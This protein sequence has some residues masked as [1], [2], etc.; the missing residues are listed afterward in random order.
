M[1]KSY[2]IVLQSEARRHIP[3]VERFSFDT[4][5]PYTERTTNGIALFHV[6]S[7]YFIPFHTSHMSHLLSKKTCIVL[8]PQPSAIT[9]AGRSPVSPPTLCLNCVEEYRKEGS[10]HFSSRDTCHS[11]DWLDALLGFFV[12][13]LYSSCPTLPSLCHSCLPSYI[14]FR[15]QFKCLT[16]CTEFRFGK[17]LLSGGYLAN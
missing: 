5:S 13:L 3:I 10:Q 15:N 14:P 4:R 12:Y 16:G 2:Y 7:C 9:V 17:I 1:W 11:E 6:C 8:L